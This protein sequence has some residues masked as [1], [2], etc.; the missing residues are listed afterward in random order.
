MKIG[1]E[2]Y[3]VESSYALVRHGFIISEENQTD[4]ETNKIIRTY[5]VFYND[6]PPYIA[7]P[8]NGI[9]KEN[10]I[11]AEKGQAL[12]YATYLRSYT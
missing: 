3:A 10:E 9:H 1:D 5:T 12:A 8:E 7:Y 11:F 4:F 2:V 6:N